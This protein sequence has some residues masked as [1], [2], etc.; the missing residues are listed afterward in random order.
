MN[1][2]GTNA[3][4]IDWHKVQQVVKWTVYVL[5]LVNWVYYI[6][7]DANRAYHVLT[8]ESTWLDWTGEFATSIDV[9]AW[10]I[11]L[12]MFELETYILGD[13]EWT[14]WVARTVRG[15]RM[16]CFVMIAHTVK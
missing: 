1:S 15:V 13:K 8:P 2:S 14:G 7:E 5:L 16:L 4:S 6:F 12:F 9:S 3:R 11:L 10:F